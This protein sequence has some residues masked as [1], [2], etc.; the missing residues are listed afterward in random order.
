MIAMERGKYYIGGKL[1]GLEL[2]KR[3]AF[4]R[5]LTGLDRGLT[6]VLTRPGDQ[7]HHGRSGALG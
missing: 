7:R 5:G 2:P 4:D 1:H 3:C 6:G